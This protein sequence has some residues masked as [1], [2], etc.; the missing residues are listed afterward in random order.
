MWVKKLIS[1]IKNTSCDKLIFCGDII[2]GWQSKKMNRLYKNHSKFIKTLLKVAERDNTKIIFVTGSEWDYKEQNPA[3]KFSNITF[4][5]QYKFTSGGNSFCVFPGDISSLIENT[6][7]SL[8][9]VSKMKHDFLLWLNKKYNTR[10]MNQGRYY[11]SLLKK[12]SNYIEVE[13]AVYNLVAE[14][15]SNLIE[16][17]LKKECE[18]IICGHAIYSGIYHLGGITFLSSGYWTESFTALAESN[19]GKWKVIDFDKVMSEKQEAIQH[20]DILDEL[21][22]EERN[23]NPVDLP[24]LT[25]P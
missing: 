18:G 14:Y 7:F 10:R 3:F 22:K 1:F 16:L 20:T 12:F 2:K 5:K 25:K 13:S 17:A 21:F 11:D 9:P 8:F 4:A 24:D 15:K 19:Y 23:E 6:N